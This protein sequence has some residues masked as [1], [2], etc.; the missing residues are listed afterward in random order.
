[1]PW[2][3]LGFHLFL[4]TKLLPTACQEKTLY[5]LA[6]ASL[7]N[8]IPTLSPPPVTCLLG[9]SSPAKLASLLF[10]ER[11]APA[12]APLHFDFP[13]SYASPQ[14]LPIAGSFSTFRFQL[15]CHL[16]REVF[17]DIPSK[18]ALPTLWLIT[19]F[20]FLHRT[21]HSL[22]L[23]IC[24]MFIVHCPYQTVNSMRAETLSVLFSAVTP[25]LS[26]WQVPNMGLL[27]NI[28][29]GYLPE[30]WG[31]TCMMSLCGVVPG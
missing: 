27:S 6:L 25:V 20:Y 30:H 1:M 17:P 2:H 18:V 9:H 31:V 8:L 24:Y 13:A 29:L 22:K 15:K 19:L 23:F 10:L 4:K 5:D 7:S 16:L 14:V 3:P 12:S 11:D 26:T 28:V 21:L